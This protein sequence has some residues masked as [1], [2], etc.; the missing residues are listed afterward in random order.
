MDTTSLKK[1][2]KPL[3]KEC[4]KEVLM[5]E[6][7]VKVIKEYNSSTSENQ[8]LL[9]NE[10]EAQ[11]MIKQLKK[12]AVQKR[13]IVAEQLKKSPEFNGFNPFDG[14]DDIDSMEKKAKL[15]EGVSLNKLIDTDMIQSWNQQLDIIERKKA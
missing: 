13:S 8:V 7:L 2:I 10:P 3:I 4:L 11:P 1:V 6:G 12:E 15:N 9:R 5:E 14:T